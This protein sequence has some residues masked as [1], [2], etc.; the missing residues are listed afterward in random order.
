MPPTEPHLEPFNNFLQVQKEY[1]AMNLDQWSSFQRFAEEVCPR[2]ADTSHAQL[3]KD[4]AFLA[5]SAEQ[6]HGILSNCNF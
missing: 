5:I 1:R 3:S 2:T 4:V 6:Y